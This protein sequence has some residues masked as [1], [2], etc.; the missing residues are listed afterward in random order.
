MLKDKL[1]WLAFALIGGGL[2]LWGINW[3][4]NRPLFLDEANI[5]RNLYDLPFAGLFSPLEHR[6]YAPPLY[7]VL[8][9][10][11]GELFGYSERSLRLPAM[12]GGILAIHGLLVG[13]KA[14]NL[15]WWT[16]L[17][18]G[19]LLVNPTAF[20]FVGEVKPYGLDLGIAALLIGY[21]LKGFRPSWQWALCGSIAVWYSLPAVFVLAA[22]GIH[23][24]IQ[25]W[26]EAEPSIKTLRPW[27]LTAGAWILSFAVLYVTVLAPS[28]GSKYLNIFHLPYF[29]PLPGQDDYWATAGQLLLSYPKL[30][31]G[32]TA[33]AIGLGTVVALGSLVFLRKEGVS[34]LLLPLLFVTCASAFGYFSL[35]P[36]LLLFT[37]PGWWLLA[38]RLSQYASQK[39]PRAITPLIIG[40]WLLVLG[41]TNILR[42][43]SSTA[44][45][46]DAKALSWELEPGYHPILHHGA[47]PGFDYYQRIHPQGPMVDTTA[48]TSSIRVAQQP[49]NYVLLYDVLTQGN[50]RISA[51]QDSI[52][53]TE[54]GCKVRSKHFYRAKALYVECP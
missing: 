27:L 26:R 35:I 53:A 31:F 39:S 50:I 22:L 52:W 5:A 1:W 18:L 12:L 47:V 10:I 16:L 46:S 51:Q 28:I 54:R 37:L 21:G 3:W 42:H 29:F 15:R 23:Y 48:E 36:R 32:F 4:A 43:F 17:P 19:L 45:F 44:T 25:S 33:V 8:A 20:R 11:C 24:F 41:G 14:I 34:W 7:L 38:G 13:S 49:G 2:L 9:K 40:L 30:A 6:Q